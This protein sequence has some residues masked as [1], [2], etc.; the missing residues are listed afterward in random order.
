MGLF[1]IF[2]TS[3]YEM[4]FLPTIVLDPWIHYFV[5]HKLQNANE[6][7]MSTIFLCSNFSMGELLD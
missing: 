2:F 3:K 1:F 7:K 5:G 6:K 4:K